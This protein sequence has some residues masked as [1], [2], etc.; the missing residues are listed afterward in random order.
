MIWKNG[1]FL[2]DDAAVVSVFDSSMRYGDGVFDMTRSFNG[3]PFMLPEHVDRFVLGCQRLDIRHGYSAAALRAAYENLLQHNQ[4]TRLKEHRGLLLAGRGCIPMYADHA[5]VR[6]A[7]GRMFPWVMIL[8]NP[9]D[10]VIRGNEHVYD[11]IPA[12]TRLA[13]PVVPDVKHMSRLHFRLAEMAT[14]PG[15]WTIT[16][17]DNSQVLEA[18]GA[19]VFGVKDGVVYSPGWGCLPGISAKFVQGLC[20]REGILHSSG[21]FTLDFLHECDEVFL[22]C[23]PYSIVPVE[24]VDGKRYAGRAGV[25]YTHLRDAWEE[26]VEVDFQNQIREMAA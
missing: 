12:E 19:N 25:V 11:G 6:A 16:Y 9:L 18:T 15:Y 4:W 24:W 21:T 2:N 14:L 23:T 10:W 5:S 8:V 3:D 26:E 13:A 20:R 1:R 17:D 7:E 22:T